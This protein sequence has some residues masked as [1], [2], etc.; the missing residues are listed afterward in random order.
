M[1]NSIGSLPRITSEIKFDINEITVVKEP[2]TIVKSIK[3]KIVDTHVEKLTELEA[4]N[5]K[6]KDLLNLKQF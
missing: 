4:Q 5:L 6:L 2:Q 1:C 3:R